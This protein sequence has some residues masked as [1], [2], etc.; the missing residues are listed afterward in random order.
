MTSIAIAALAIAPVVAPS[1]AVHAQPADARAQAGAAF[2]RAVAAEAQQEWATA[3]REYELAYQLSPHPDV[4]FNLA[5]VHERTGAHR[6]A[7]VHYQR[8]LD[9]SPKAADRTAVTAK[10]QALRL[11]PAKLTVIARPVG[12][13]VVIDGKRIGGAPVT[14]ELRGGAHQITVESDGAQ[15]SR[16]V[17]LEY[18]EPQRVELAVAAGEGTLVVTSNAKDATVTI[19]GQA[20]GTAPW[21]GTVSAGPHTVVIAATGYTTTERAVDVPADG[22]AQIQGSLGR[23]VGWVEPTPPSKTTVRFAF[24]S[25]AYLGHGYQV[26]ISAL[27]RTGG[28]RAEVGTGFQFGTDGLAWA[29]R[30]RLFLLTGAVRPYVVGAVNYGFNG[31]STA[32]AGGGV[33]L[34]TRGGLPMD[35]YVESGYGVGQTFEDDFEFVPVMAGVSFGR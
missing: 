25:G 21:T 1:T 22:T 28:R 3:I 2:K 11:H 35:F 13:T 5:A 23:P 18:G 9:D 34:P 24:D 27:Y 10:L 16:V 4:L 15:A 12:A 17:T 8:Y 31:D 26:G 6:T 33:L 32:Y 29:L 14:R 30:G 19:D 20:V 7:A